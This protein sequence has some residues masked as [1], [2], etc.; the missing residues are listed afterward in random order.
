MTNKPKTEQP[1]AVTPQATPELENCGPEC[2]E[3]IDETG[4]DTFPASDPPSSG[5]TTGPSDTSSRG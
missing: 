3:R 5:Q 1:D 2:Q 4:R